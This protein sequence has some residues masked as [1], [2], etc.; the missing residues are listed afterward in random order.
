M[1]S[2]S[3]KEANKIRNRHQVVS[4]LKENQ[5]VLRKTQNQIKQ[6]SDLERLISKIAAGKVSPVEVIYLKESLDAIIPIK[7]LALESKQE[8]VK[9]IGDSLHS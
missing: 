4:Y 1:V 5:E 2:A 9:I 7:T 6:I 8:A 3:I